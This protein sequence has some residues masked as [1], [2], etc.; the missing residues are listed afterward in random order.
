MKD[1]GDA[2][3]GELAVDG[4]H[5]ADGVALKAQRRAGGVA[6]AEVPFER[7]VELDGRVGDPDLQRPGGLSVEDEVAVGVGDISLVVAKD[8]VADD[9]GIQ[10]Q[11]GDLLLKLGPQQLHQ[12]LELVLHPLVGRGGEQHHGVGLLAQVRGQLEA[13]GGIERHA[14]LAP[15][16]TMRL[17]EHDLQ[18]SCKILNNAM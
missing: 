8:H 10:R 12:G 18:M 2:G 5:E 11:R 14:V 1:C 3:G 7:F 15:A 13:L 16:E 17:V 6:P 9:L 4:H